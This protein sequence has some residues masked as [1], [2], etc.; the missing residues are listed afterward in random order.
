M[1]IQSVPSNKYGVEQSIFF[2]YWNPKEKK[3]RGKEDSFY[4][5]Y[6]AYKQVHCYSVNNQESVMLWE[7]TLLC[8]L[9]T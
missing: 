5:N 3:N 1:L 9:G 2:W 7:Y 4:V 6:E 8:Q